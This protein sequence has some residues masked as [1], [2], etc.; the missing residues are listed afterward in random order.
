MDY[1]KNFPPLTIL[2]AGCGNGRDGYYMAD[3]HMVTGIDNCGIQ[4]ENRSQFNFI[5]DTFITIDKSAYTLIYSRFTFHSITNE[6]HLRFLSTIKSG[7][8]LVIEARSD[9]ETIDEYYGKSHYRNYINMKYLKSILIDFD[10]LYIKEGKD[11]AIYKTEN[12]VC[13]RVIC[14]KL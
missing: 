13:V 10:I 12:P 2:D 9:K 14:R 4:L 11:M 1:F 8:Y 6:D 3:K 5:N 7:T